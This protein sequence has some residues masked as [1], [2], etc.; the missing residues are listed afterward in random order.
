[1]AEVGASVDGGIGL[2]HLSKSGT[3]QTVDHHVYLNGQ[4]KINVDDM[5]LDFL[6]F[7]SIQ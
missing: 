5:M 3:E 2:R 4:R 1:M 7:T 6:Q